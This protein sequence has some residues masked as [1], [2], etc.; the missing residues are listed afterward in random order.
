MQEFAS[1]QAPPSCATGFEQAPVPVSH[2]PASWHASLGVH[3][4]GL[5]AEHVPDTH[6]SAWVQALK[7]VHELPSGFTGFEQTPFDGLHV[8]AMWQLFSAAQI[9][10]VP[11]VHR[12]DWHVSDCVHALPSEHAVPFGLAGFEQTPVR[13][14]HVP[15]M[16][17]A[18][19][20]TH[21]TGFV[22]KHVPDW[23]VSV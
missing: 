22:P 13:G 3:T 6:V 9:T 21:V 7:S 5:P 2:V 20:A 19:L 12:P 18:S 10:L 1:L 14:P 11:P 23:Q 16:W 8:P 15:A 4:T 17:H